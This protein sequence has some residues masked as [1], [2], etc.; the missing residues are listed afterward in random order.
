MNF[1][2]AVYNDYKASADFISD[3]VGKVRLA[4]ILGSGL[5]DF[6]E[7]I[8]DPVVIPYRDIPNFPVS[9]VSYQKGE[10]IYGEVRGT[11][12]KVLAMNGRFTLRGLGDVADRLFR[13]GFHLL[14][15]D[16]YHHNGR[17]AYPRIKSGRSRL[18]SETS[19]CAGQ[20]VRG[21]ISTAFGKRF[22]YA[23]RL[24]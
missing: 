6:A 5:G 23:E 4:V 11:G 2:K 7:T 24:R 9:T 12:K 19:I 1:R 10:L 8:V 22:S 21:R 3:R 13:S 17:A 15:V 18:V 20:S 16:R 14:G